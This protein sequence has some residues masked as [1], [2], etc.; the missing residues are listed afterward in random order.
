MIAGQLPEMG[1]APGALL[2]ASAFGPGALSWDAIY[3]MQY[4]A[5]RPADPRAINL[6]FGWPGTP[7][8]MSDISKFLDWSAREHDVLYVKS[9]GN[10][11]QN[12]PRP[13]DSFNGLNVGATEKLLTDGQQVFRKVWAGSEFTNATDGRRLSHIVAPGAGIKMPRID[14]DEYVADSGTSFAAPHATGTVALLQEYG[15]V[16]INTPHWDGDHKHH[17]VMKAV[18]MNSADKI[19]DEDGGLLLG[20]EKT[21]LRRDGNN[22]L[23]SDA[24]ASTVLPVD[25]ELDTGQ[26]NAFRAHQQLVPGEWEPGNV[27]P[28]GWDYGLTIPRDSGK[29]YVIEPKLVK[30]SYISITLVWD[31]FVNLVEPFPVLQDGKW[32]NEETLDASAIH[33]LNLYLRRVDTKE[34]IDK[35]ESS[36]YNVEHIFWQLPNDAD[37]EYEIVVKQATSGQGQL[38]AIAWWAF[39]IPGPGLGLIIGDLPTAKA[40]WSPGDFFDRRSEFAGSEVAAWRI[41]EEAYSANGMVSRSISMRANGSSVELVTVASSPAPNT[42]GTTPRRV[43][44]ASGAFLDDSFIE[45]ELIQIHERIAPAPSSR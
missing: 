38:Y 3:A 10:A 4:V 35:S 17:E 28:I 11:G 15:D 14:Q 43:F 22:W 42:D 5:T 33:D 44:P 36:V 32:N 34:I 30:G 31:R 45:S 40:L 6:S 39:P 2:H 27:P 21:I 8:G 23:A 16:R 9:R 20:M 1:V 25:N 13:V 29:V 18:L 41:P 7:D 37:R 12:Q 19:K 24:Y 26:L